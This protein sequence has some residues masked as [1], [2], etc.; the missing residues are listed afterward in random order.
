MHSSCPCGEGVESLPPLQGS[1]SKS[2]GVWLIPNKSRE[3]EQL[4]VGDR[5]PGQNFPALFS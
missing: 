1:E 2:D 4:T 3:Q 5:N